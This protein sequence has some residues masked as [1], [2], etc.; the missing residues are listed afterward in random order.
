MRVFAV[1]TQRMTRIEYERLVDRGVID[2]DDPVE[3]LEGLLVLREPQGSRHA[4][5]SLR[6]RVA[7]DRV[8]GRGCHVR[9]QYPVALDDMSEPE[10][11]IAV[12]RG[13]IDDYLDAHPVLPVLVVEVSDSTLVKDRVN[14]G[15][16]YA[17]AGVPDYWI[18]NVRSRT[19]GV[20]RD[21]AQTTSGRWH[22]R[23]VRVVKRG[24]TVTPLAAP[25]ARLRVSALL[26]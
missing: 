7:L 21:P 24:G 5:V 23:T 25:R 4:A 6:L 13:R 1:L 14:K 15:A 26:P 20:Y 2:E 18:A 11:D 8:F 22:Y 10:P 19:L 12:V 16:L 3:L 17:R 9:N